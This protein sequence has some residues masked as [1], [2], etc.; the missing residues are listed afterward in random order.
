[1]KNYLIFLNKINCSTFV[2]QF[3][4]VIL[5]FQLNKVNLKSLN[6]TIQQIWNYLNINFYQSILN[7]CKNINIFV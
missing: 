5:I 1:M 3:Y 6:K 4:C 2:F 7:I